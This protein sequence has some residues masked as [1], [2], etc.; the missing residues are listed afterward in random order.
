[1]GIWDILE[2]QATKDKEQIQVAYRKKLTVTNPEDSPEAFMALRQAFEEAMK[3]AEE[4]NEEQEQQAW[5]DSPLGRWMERIDDLYCHFSKRIDPQQWKVLLREDVCQNLD[6]RIKARDELLAYMMEHFFLPQSVV[7]LLDEHFSLRE[8]I[9]EL[10]E[11]FPPQFLDVVIVQSA[12]QKEYPPYEYLQGDDG[13]DFDQYLLYGS[14]LNECL[15]KGNAKAALEVIT[16]MEK[17]GVNSPFLLIDKAKAYCQEKRFQEAEALMRELVPRYEE[18]EDVKLMQGDVCFFLGKVQEA[19]QAYDAVL[20]QVPD[21]SWAKFGM[22][23]CLTEEGSYKEA[24]EIFCQLLDEDPYDA[25]ALEWLRDCNER[26]KKQLRQEL[27]AAG[28]SQDQ[29]ALFELAWCCFQNEGYQEVLRLLSDIRPEAGREIEYHS[30]MGRSYL[31]GDQDDVALKHLKIWEELLE[32]IP[33]D[34]EKGKKKKEQF[35]FVLLLESNIHS[36]KGEYDQALKLL[37]QALK[38]DPSYGLALEQK[39]QVLYDS[40]NLPEAVETLT[41]S[42]AVN[43]KSHLSYLLRGKALYLMDQH[44]AAFDDCE[45]ALALYPFELTAHLQ[46]ARILTDAGEYDQAAGV[47]EYLRQEGLSG[48]EIR[49]MEGYLQEGKG[50]LKSAAKIYKEIVQHKKKR[51]KEDSFELDDFAEVYYRLA[52]L[53]Y[54]DDMEDFN[55]V[56]QLIDQGMRE[57]ERYVPLLEMKAHIACQCGLFD[58]A[59]ALYEEVLK[60]APGKVGTYGMMDRVYR[61][62]EQWDKAL[63]YAELQVE[64]TPTGYAYMR[65]GQLFTCLDR[66]TEAW[67]DFVMASKL[68][69]E[70]PYIYNYMGVILEFDSKEQEALTYYEKAISLGEEEGEFCDEA[71]RNAANLYCRKQEHRKAG[72]L[73][74]AAYEAT[75]DARY[76]CEELENWRLGGLFDQA[77]ETLQ[78]YRKAARLEEGS[79]AFGWEQAHIY[80][81]SGKLALALE[82]YDKLGAF[83]PTACRE[84]AKILYHNGECQKALRYLK[85]AISM[86]SESHEIEED[87]FSRADY[88]LW[89]AKACLRMGDKA[90]AA[91]LAEQGLGQISEEVI[92]TKNSCLPMV[93]QLVGGLCGAMEEY[94]DALEFLEGA[95][96]MRKCDYC[97]YNCCIDALYELGDLFQ[98]QGDREKALEYYQKGLAA[99]P[100]DSDLAQEAALLEKGVEKGKS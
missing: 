45:Q 7:L 38:K 39:G 77:E 44:G 64:Q 49:F 73:L 3:A 30:L 67:D 14:K 89:A 68:S 58:K 52:L 72:K 36:S 50:D 55:H 5:D 66:R 43:P 19:R 69:P 21:S 35:P 11:L 20:K 78:L 26:Y 59:L 92:K 100:F 83:E 12:E 80:R 15:E 62:L 31:Y 57:N 93:Y 94:A 34:S 53:E 4:P 46:E 24:N 86:L 90:E 95:L 17:T 9:E 18:L 13:L 85:R 32:K 70:Q 97:D 75:G 33:D 41:D 2:I 16:L 91:R 1:M 84:A 6:M 29:E 99:A 88:Y 27:E 40:W 47:L 63:E 74:R 82:C 37:D 42:I 8:N 96:R 81:D 56:I 60:I 98:Q 71:Y 22:A 48:S 61:E 76:L 65:R 28:D 51:E 87:D 23:K 25:S 10:K 79:F 54:D